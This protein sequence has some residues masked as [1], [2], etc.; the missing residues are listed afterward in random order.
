[1]TT[2][3]DMIPGKFYRAVIEG[4]C[5]IARGKFKYIGT[6]NN[7]YTDKYYLRDD[8][9]T[10]TSLEEIPPTYPVGTVVIRRWEGEQFPELFTH[11]E[12]GWVNNATQAKI[13]P[14]EL[15][16]PASDTPYS[17]TVFKP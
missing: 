9:A 16:E 5:V 2:V 14:E 8:M 17:L 4:E 6:P 10:L 1:M 12:Y 15:F 13:A 11:V 7:P 3:E